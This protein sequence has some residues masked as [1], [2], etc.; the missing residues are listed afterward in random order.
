MENQ[1]EE[2][3]KL[4]QEL[5]EGMTPEALKNLTTEEMCCVIEQMAQ[6]KGKIAVL[7]DDE[8]KENEE[9]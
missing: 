3:L 9:E 6:I 4:L 5:E 1:Y 2:V 7:K 8:E